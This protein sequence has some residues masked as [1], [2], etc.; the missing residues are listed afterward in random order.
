VQDAEETLGDDL[1]AS[2]VIV[3]PREAAPLCNAALLNPEEIGIRDDEHCES[4]LEA[5]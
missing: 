2:V 5:L 3:K 1:L 4:G